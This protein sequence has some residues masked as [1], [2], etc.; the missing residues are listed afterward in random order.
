[1]KRSL[2]LL[3]LAA[4][5]LA[6][7]SPRVLEVDTAFGAGTGTYDPVTGLT[8]LDLTVTTNISW[9]DMAVARAP[10]GLYE[11]WRYATSPELA[12][13]Y[14]DGFGYPIF[15]STADKA[16][17][18]ETMLSYLGTLTDINNGAGWERIGSDGFLGDA[19]GLG[20]EQAGLG[21]DLTNGVPSSA[22][23]ASDNWGSAVDNVAF[24]GLGHWLVMDTPPC[25]DS[26][27]DTVCDDED[28]LLSV[29]PAPAVGGSVTFSVERGVPGT[30]VF[31]LASTQ[32]DSGGPCRTSSG[33]TVCV[34]VVSPI[35]IGTRTVSPAGTAS[36]TVSV[37]ASVT[38]GMPVWFQAVYL[39]PG[40]GDT[41]QVL[42]FDVAGAP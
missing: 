32:G 19:G 20:H 39:V 38:P 22:W 9:N 5:S 16:A 18:V 42:A 15:G 4:P 8:W 12:E 27:G 30:R 13:L 10:G 31:F 26:D 35:I 23:A 7:A 37:P 36:M 33:A 3:A 24:D 17:S 25:A 40:Q 28:F 21:R 2:F 41:T 34:D 1:M 14:E 29:S 11:G 6:L